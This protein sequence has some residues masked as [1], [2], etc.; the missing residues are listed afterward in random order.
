MP[1]IRT[2]L[3]LAILLLSVAACAPA[4]DATTGSPAADDAE[5]PAMAAP[6]DAGQTRVPRNAL[7]GNCDAK[8]AQS[9]VGQVA[10][11][12]IA[13]Q[14]RAA[15]GARGVRVLKPGQMVTLEHNPG[16][17]NLDVDEDNVII[18]ARCG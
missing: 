13:E 6:R 16:R 12:E 3:P 2:A 8:A 7:T 9:L 18:R 5:P 1:T 17:L 11:P 10:T 14:A 4:R 15:A